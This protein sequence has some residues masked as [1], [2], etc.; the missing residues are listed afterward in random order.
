MRELRL[1]HSA[2]KLFCRRITTDMS[3]VS[4]D[5]IYFTQKRKR[6]GAICWRALMLQI[7]YSPESLSKGSGVDGILCKLRSGP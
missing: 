2:L 1:S 5:K 4:V 6:I 7:R 3:L